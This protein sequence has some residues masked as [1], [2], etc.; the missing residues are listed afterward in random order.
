MRRRGRLLRAQANYDKK[1]LRLLSAKH[2]IVGELIED[3]QESK[4]HE[5]SNCQ[6]IEIAVCC[7]RSSE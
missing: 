7:T 1:H 3:I 4:C 6:Q 5:E 2:P